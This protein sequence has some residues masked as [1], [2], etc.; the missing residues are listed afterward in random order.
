MNKARRVSRM[1]GATCQVKDEKE[2]RQ[3][4][5][6][7]ERRQ[8]ER[9]TQK[10]ENRLKRVRRESLKTMGVKELRA[11]AQEKG[12]KGRSKMTKDELVKAL[13]G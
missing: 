11:L 9:M 6:H 5:V 2:W 3:G 13:V 1:Y 4:R 10:R 8:V 12:T 7:S